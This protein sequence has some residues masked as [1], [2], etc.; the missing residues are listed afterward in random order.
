MNEAILIWLYLSLG[1]MVTLFWFMFTFA[2]IVTVVM[3]INYTST[4]S[5]YGDSADQEYTWAVLEID[6]VKHYPDLF[7]K[8]LP[9]KTVV[10]CM[11][12]ALMYPSKDDLKYIIG[13]SVAFNAVQAMGNLKG[14]DKLPQNLIDAANRFLESAKEEENTDVTE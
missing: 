5:A 1:S 12:V 11:L 10:F 8:F 7:K 4:L 6:K 2:V 14:A 13:G 3:G 9:L